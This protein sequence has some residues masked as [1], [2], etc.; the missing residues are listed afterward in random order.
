MSNNLY[1]AYEE[2]LSEK[3]QLSLNVGRDKWVQ[4]AQ[5]GLKSTLSTYLNGLGTV[6]MESPTKGYVSLVGTFP[7]ML[8]N[9]FNKFDMKNGFENSP[10]KKIG[11][12]GKWYLTIP[13]RHSINSNV[14]PK[15]NMPT[16]VYEKA[17]QL[18][19][20]EYLSESLVRT[21]GY[22]PQTSFTGYQ[23]KNSKYDGMQHI[24]K[25][26]NS[27]KSIGQ[28]I[29]FRRVGENTDEK[30]WQHPGYKGI[31]ALPKVEKAVADFFYE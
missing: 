23:W 16:S 18:K 15:S 12:N 25:T 26:Y 27:G 7:G 11:K 13:Y 21:L 3:L 5:K 9:G 1:K 14:T 31:K 10:K 30:A 17:K 4:E 24:V 29:T 2:F 20:T 6:V 22:S 19:G 28:Y 8:E